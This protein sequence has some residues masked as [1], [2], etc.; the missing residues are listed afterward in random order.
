M[1]LQLSSFLLALA[2]GTAASAHGGAASAPVPAPVSAEF[3]AASATSSPPSSP[4]ANAPADLKFADMFRLP[5]GPRG[6]E[7]SARLLAL[8]GGQVRLIGY[9]A[10][11]EHAVAGRLVLAP[12]PVSLGDEDD[13]LS[14]DLP[15]SAVF[16]H[17]SADHADRVLPNF[18]GLMQLTGTLQLGAQDEPDGHVSSLR[19]LLDAATSQRLAEAADRAAAAAV[20][21]P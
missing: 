10:S 6:L 14:D 5:V 11:T 21:R 9:M 17:L 8:A 12:L 16:V 7:P 4:T 20:R 13:S 3:A 19:L 18:G 2:C 1:N 15:A